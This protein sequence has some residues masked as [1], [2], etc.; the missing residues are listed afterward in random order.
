MSLISP[1][2]FSLNMQ[3]SINAGPRPNVFWPDILVGGLTG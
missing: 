1:A 3:I 2:R